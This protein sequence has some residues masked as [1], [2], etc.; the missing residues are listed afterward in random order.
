MRFLVQATPERLAR[1]RPPVRAFL[2][3]AGLALA[4]VVAARVTAGGLTAAGVE[5]AYL[6]DGQPLPLAALW[7]EVHMGAFLQGFTLL[8]LGS[9]VAVCPGPARWRNALFALAVAATLA[10]LF[11]PFAVVALRGAGGLRVA[12][13]AV[14]TLAQAG[15]LTWGALG[16]GRGRA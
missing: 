9:I 2:L 10:D 14:A 15:L 11:A 4:G 3:F 13:F 1:A 8:M 7:E 5:A 12:T 6:G 16:F